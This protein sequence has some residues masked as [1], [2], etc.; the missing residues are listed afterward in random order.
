MMKLPFTLAAAAALS[1]TLS[2]V[3]PAKAQRADAMMFVAKA[4]AGDLYEVRS[5]Q[6]AVHRAHDPRVRA[7]AGMLIRDHRRTTAQ[8]TAAAR[9]AGLR[10]GPPALERRQRIMINQ[11][12][13]AP[14]RRFDQVYLSQQIPAHQEALDMHRSYSANGSVSSLRRV[15][16]SAVPIVESH[17]AEARRLQH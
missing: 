2:F 4:G 1:A 9:A 6:I 5:S 15:A 3:A 12:N 10:P 8:V 14:A 13:R 17:L 11:L 16:T 7:F